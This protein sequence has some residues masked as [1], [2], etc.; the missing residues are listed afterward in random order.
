MNKNTKNKEKVYN[1]RIIVMSDGAIK[2]SR[3]EKYRRV[4]QHRGDWEIACSRDLA[5]LVNK[6]K[7][8]IKSTS[9]G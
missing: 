4:N 1:A 5:R 6:S 9:L 2:I 7:I 3:A 8:V